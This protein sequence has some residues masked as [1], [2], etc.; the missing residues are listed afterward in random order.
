MNCRSHHLR[1]LS[2]TVCSSV[3]NICTHLSFQK[4]PFTKLTM[5]D[6]PKY[7]MENLNRMYENKILTD[8]T[9][10]VDDA[11]FDCHRN[12]LAAASPYFR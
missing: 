2:R 11:K 10:Q 5:D 4:N 9:L 7:L 8:V 1:L 3:S 12:V 6:Y